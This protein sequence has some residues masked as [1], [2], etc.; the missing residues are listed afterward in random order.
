MS[1]RQCICGLGWAAQC[2]SHPQREPEAREMF[3]ALTP[4]AIIP[5]CT[6]SNAECDAQWKE[7]LAAAAKAVKARDKAKS[8]A[9]SCPD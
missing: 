1:D 5:Y 8:A 3:P 9:K 6:K 4:G 7:V 2:P